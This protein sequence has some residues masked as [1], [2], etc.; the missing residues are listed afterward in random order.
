MTHRLTLY[1]LLIKNAMTSSYDKRGRREKRDDR[2][3]VPSG[4]AARFSGQGRRPL[5]YMSL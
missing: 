1:I 2:M 4:G 5:F 3:P